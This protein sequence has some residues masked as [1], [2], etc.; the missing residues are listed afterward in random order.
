MVHLSRLY[1]VRELY[2]RVCAFAPEE[3]ARD[4]NITTINILNLFRPISLFQF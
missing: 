3:W 2:T 4:I 1:S